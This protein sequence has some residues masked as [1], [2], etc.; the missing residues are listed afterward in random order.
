MPEI[1]KTDTDGIYT[2][3]DKLADAIRSYQ[4][5]DEAKESLSNGMKDILTK[6][7]QILMDVIGKEFNKPS[8]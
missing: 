5:S 8:E 3:A 6:I 1:K 4:P 2:I 7:L